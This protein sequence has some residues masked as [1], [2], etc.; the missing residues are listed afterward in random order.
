MRVGSLAPG[1]VATLLMLSSC[2]DALFGQYVEEKQADP[3]AVS[4]LLCRRDVEAV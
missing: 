3:Y 2:P 4:E 1:E